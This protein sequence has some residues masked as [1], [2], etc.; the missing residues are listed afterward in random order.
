MPLFSRIVLGS[1]MDQYDDATG[2]V[3]DSETEVRHAKRRRQ[4]KRPVSRSIPEDVHQP[5]DDIHDVL[6]QG[7]EDHY[8]PRLIP[9]IYSPIPLRPYLPTIPPVSEQQVS[10]LDAL[11]RI[12]RYLARTPFQAQHWNGEVPSSRSQSPVQIIYQTPPHRRHIT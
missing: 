10:S 4:R 7:H 5:E 1:S 12:S 3:S 2:I 11:P 9:H 6:I 8:M